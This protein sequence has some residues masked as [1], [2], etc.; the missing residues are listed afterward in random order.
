LDTQ[1]IPAS[2]ARAF[3][4]QL[5]DGDDEDNQAGQLQEPAVQGDAQQTSEQ[6]LQQAQQQSMQQAQYAAYPYAMDTLDRQAY[7]Q[8]LAG[9]Q[10]HAGQ[11]FNPMLMGGMQPGNAGFG[12]YM[13][14]SMYDPRDAMAASY[15]LGPFQGAHACLACFLC[16]SQHACDKE[17]TSLVGVASRRLPA[18]AATADAA[19]STTAAAAADAAADPAAAAAAAAARAAGCSAAGLAGA[20]RSRRLRAAHAAACA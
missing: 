1:L 19:A 7:A 10:Q 5:T 3:G 8:Q 17:V 15:G 6:A 20:G 2:L 14:A 13:P 11:G 16:F 12:A 9:F 4:L 18:A